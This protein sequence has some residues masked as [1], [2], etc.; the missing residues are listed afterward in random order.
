MAPAACARVE[1]LLP[2]ASSRF[3]SSASFGALAALA[4]LSM[5]ALVSMPAPAPRLNPIEV[6][7]AS[8]SRAVNGID[9]R[10]LSFRTTF[11]VEARLRRHIDWGR[12]AAL[13]D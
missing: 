3:F 9:G 6:T 1:I 4:R 11:F 2:F 12:R 10:H 13:R 7:M 5:S 8:L